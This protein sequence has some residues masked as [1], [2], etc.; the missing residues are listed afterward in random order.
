MKA[1]RIDGKRTVITGGGSGLGFGI[2][3]IFIEAGAEVVI[4]GQNKQKLVDA[5][6]ALGERCH[7]KQFNITQLHE[8]PLLVSEIQNSIG[9]VD[10]LV[11]CAGVH[12][13]KNATE[14]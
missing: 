4:I 8:I 3:K 5:K 11:N 10:I 1:F 7:Y 14:T 2:A 9:P 12:L 13:K 6:A